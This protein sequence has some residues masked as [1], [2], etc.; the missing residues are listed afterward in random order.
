MKKITIKEV[1]E[2]AGVSKTTISRYLNNNYGN[3]SKATKEKISEVIKTLNYRPSKQAQALK[4][5]RSYLIGIVVAD[6]SNLYSSLLLKGIGSVLEKSGYQMIIMDAANSVTQEKEL[7]EKLL[8]Q[9]VEGII[10]QPSSR[11]STNYEFITEHN[12]PLLLVDRQTEPQIWTSVLTNNVAATKEVLEKILAK[13]YEE[14]VVVSEPIKEVSTRELRYQTVAESVQKAGKI[15]TLIELKDER[16]L[17]EKI[18]PILENPKKSLLFAS[19]G[20]MLMDLLTYLIEKK[21]TIPEQIGI[22]GFDDWNLTSLVG[23]GITSIEQPSRKIG[24]VAAKQLLEQLHV[25]KEVQE[26]IVPSV[27]Q[28]RQSI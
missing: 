4:S 8:D 27:I 1:A 14:V 10:L 2:E 18:Q 17:P 12:I 19:N 13:G 16:S 3:M 26:I 20:R 23:P 9:S 6:I 7:L 11:Q 25:E 5:K 22:T 28:W 21:I 15:C 24:E